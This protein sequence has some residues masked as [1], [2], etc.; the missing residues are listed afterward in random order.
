MSNLN[1][2]YYEVRN[3]KSHWGPFLTELTA[4]RQLED[5]QCNAALSRP[6][7]IYKIKSVNNLVIGTKENGRWLLN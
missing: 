1:Q 7:A 4:D 6:F 5:L 2:Y 3:S